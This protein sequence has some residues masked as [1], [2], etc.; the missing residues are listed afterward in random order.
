MSQGTHASKAQHRSTERPLSV[1]RLPGGG[2]L[3]LCDVGAAAPV[4][5]D[6]LHVPPV[7]DEEPVVAL[8]EGEHAVLFLRGCTVPTEEGKPQVESPAPAPGSSPPA[9]GSSPT[10]H[11]TEA[12]SGAVEA[13]SGAVAT[14]ALLPT[15][16][17]KEGRVEPDSKQASV[18]PGS[19]SDEDTLDNA[20]TPLSGSSYHDTV[21]DPHPPVPSPREAAT[22]SPPR[23][24][25]PPDVALPLG[26]P[27]TGEAT[28]IEERSLGSFSHG[29]PPEVVIDKQNQD[30]AFH[31]EMRA[32]NGDTWVLCGV[33]DG[34]G[35]ATWSSRAARQ[36]AAGFI[37]GVNDFFSDARVQDLP[38][39]LVRDGSARLLASLVH[40]RVRHRIEEDATFLRAEGY[41]DPTWSP[42][43]YA[44][45]FENGPN[46]EANIRAKWFQ[47]TLLAAALG[48]RGGFV[49]LL[50]D[51][52]ARVDRELD[53]GRTDVKRLACS[54]P[55]ITLDLPERQVQA[56]IY[57]VLPNGAIRLGVMFT[58][59]G[60]SDSSPTTLADVT[61]GCRSLPGTEERHPLERVFF[62][63]AG[64]CGRVLEDLAIRP[65]DVAARDNM[66]IAF[67][68]CGVLREK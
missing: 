60:V 26:E 21:I 41:V 32:P 64:E 38:D 47:S 35:Q 57:R 20:P 5:N 48:P 8:R 56:A 4:P 49:L 34:V 24:A 55:H 68:R 25:A 54:A 13:P 9:N 30:F 44:Q 61:R 65:A 31:R 36:V 59:D 6:R 7:A 28:N 46:A 40:A 67:A 45:T 51:G 19:I 50:G 63:S 58:T 53:G 43:M 27:F 16:E 23:L 14:P 39:G 3:F 66:S 18:R 42:T 11:P 22:A 33:A 37:L 29:G 17:V 52:F 12:P 15:A 62:T 2:A 1:E 10:K